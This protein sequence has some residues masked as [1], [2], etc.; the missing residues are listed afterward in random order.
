[1]GDDTRKKEL[2]PQPI[3]D[4][5]SYLDQSDNQREIN[6]EIGCIVKEVDCKV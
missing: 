6:D 1:M 5:G 4:F 2:M 3:V